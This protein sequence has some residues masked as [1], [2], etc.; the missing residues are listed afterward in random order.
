MTK[1]TG[2]LTLI[3]VV[4]GTLCH[5][6]VT[7]IYNDTIL[8]PFSDIYLVTSLTGSYSHSRNSSRNSNSC[9]MNSSRS[10][11][12]TNLDPFRSDVKHADHAR[13]EVA[14]GFEVDATDA[15]GAVDQQHHVGLRC[16]LTLCVCREAV[17]EG[18]RAVRETSS[19]PQWQN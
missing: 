7:E 17:T 10:K 12:I 6:T 8:K 19:T 9:S 16:G 1:L 2:L 4:T 3:A 11:I 5:I 13:D 18:G 14:D 15:P